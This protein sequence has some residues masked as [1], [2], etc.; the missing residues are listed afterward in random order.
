MAAEKPSREIYD[1]L[2]RDPSRLTS[3]YAQVF[4]GVLTGSEKAT[5]G[6]EATETSYKGSVSLVSVDR[7]TVSDRAESKKESSVPHDITIVD[8]LN[9]LLLNHRI[10]DDFVNAP[11]HQL[12]R[13]SGLLCFHD[14]SH[15]SGLLDAFGT[16]YIETDKTTPKSQKKVYQT[17]IKSSAVQSCFSMSTKSGH[18]VVG[19]LKD[20][21]L[22]TP[23]TS[24]SMIHAG[25]DIDGVT[26]VGIKENGDGYTSSQRMGEFVISTSK[27]AQILNSMIVPNDAVRV[28]PLAIFRKV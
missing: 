13:A 12:V 6:R 22:E 20:A 9:W 28:V 18:I 26:V 5:T 19:A 27:I 2:Y 10:E 3:F 17:L 24:H 23:I 11:H 7:K 1:F 8:L 25:K 14:G 4:G 21:G 15:L 16:H